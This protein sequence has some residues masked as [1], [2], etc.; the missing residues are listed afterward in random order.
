MKSILSGILLAVSAAFAEVEAK[1]VFTGELARAIATVESNGNNNAVG[2]NGKAVG[3]FQIWKVYVDDVNRI[4]AL[5]NMPYKFGY[6]DRK[7]PAKSVLMVKIYTEYYGAVYELRTGKK[8]TAE[9]LARI[10]N[11]GGWQ[12]ALKP[13][14]TEYWRKVKKQI[15]EAKK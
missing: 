10:H 7:D 8:A 4:C 9:V 2:D 12:G 6:E 15:G 13:C 11:G 1:P 5:K 3:K 14:T